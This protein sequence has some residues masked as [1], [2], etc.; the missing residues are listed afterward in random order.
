MAAQSHHSPVPPLEWVGVPAVEADPRA[1]HLARCDSCGQP[2]GWSASDRL[3]GLL[4]RW[5]WDDRAPVALAQLRSR[6]LP[7]GLLMVDL[8]LFKVI[9]DEFGHLV[10]DQVL[11]ETGRALRA[12]TRA[13]D[14]ICRYGGDEFVVLLPDTSL[15]SALAV[16]RRIHVEIRVAGSIIATRLAAGRPFAG[17]TASIGA[18]ACIPD[19]AAQLHDLLSDADAA[20]RDAKRN[21]RAQTRIAYSPLMGNAATPLPRPAPYPVAARTSQE[22]P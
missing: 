3:T 18:A 22:R 21:G 8:D 6:R 11:Q 4:D 2:L 5:G 20:L 7:V 1:T 14:L 12:A 16:A 13:T 19:P 15:A 9:N 17:L 10:G